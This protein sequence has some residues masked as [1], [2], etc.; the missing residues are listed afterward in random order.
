MGYYDPD[1]YYDGD[2]CSQNLRS[3]AS[4]LCYNDVVPIDNDSETI[5]NN[6]TQG[7][8]NE[9][10]T[11]SLNL[12]S[13]VEYSDGLVD[14]KATLNNVAS[15][16]ATFNASMANDIDQIAVALNGVFDTYKGANINKP[17]LVSL[18]VGKLDY[19]GDLQALALLTERVTLFIDS[20]V[21]S[22]TLT[23]KK[24]KGGGCSRT[25]DHKPAV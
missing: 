25:S 15:A 11:M 10:K 8:I 19:K 13:C 18:T 4:E 12:N 1:D 14:L 5:N 17:A 24:G 16:V 2:Y 23:M 3:S 20:Q 6:R 21:A 9:R 22:G 7:C